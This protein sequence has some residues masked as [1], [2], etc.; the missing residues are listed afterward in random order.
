MSFT[1]GIKFPR[2][3]PKDAQEAVTSLYEAVESDLE[4]CCTLRRIATHDYMKEVW[5]QQFKNISPDMLVW[6]TFLTWNSARRIPLMHI[7][8][9]TAAPVRESASEANPFEIASQAR[10]VAK[11]LK[12]IDLEILAANK[13]TE[14]TQ[15]ELDRVAA[16]FD[17]QGDELRFWIK[18]ATPQ[19]KVRAHNADQIAFV[20]RLCSHLWSRIGLRRRP[21][22]LIAILTNVAFDV[23]AHRLWDA[24]RVK[25]CYRSRSRSK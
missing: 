21:Y 2:W 20:N 8:V 1:A 14:A 10:A 16:F 13:L 5:A 17:R 24:D 19:R 12:A 7:P 25:H 22:S 18:F 23:P 6:V 9:S 3:V 4:C 15:Q 11:A